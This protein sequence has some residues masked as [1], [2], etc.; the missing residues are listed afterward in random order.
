MNEMRNTRCPLCGAPAIIATTEN[1]YT[2]QLE[3]AYHYEEPQ[4]KPGPTVMGYDLDHLQLVAKLM[5]QH[6]VTPE[7]LHDLK[8]NFQRAFDI[9][10]TEQERIAQDVAARMLAGFQPDTAPVIKLKQEEVMKE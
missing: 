5:R 2:C 8:D 7:D 1:A 9:L 6:E 10:H 3:I 4:P